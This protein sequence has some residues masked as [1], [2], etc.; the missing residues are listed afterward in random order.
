MSVLSQ[1]SVAAD[2]MVLRTWPTGETSVVASLLTADHGYVRVIAKGARGARS[3]LRALVQPGRLAALEFSLSP[4]RDLQYLRGGQV[5]LDPLASDNTLERTAY[6]LAAVEIVDRCR[7]G[8]STDRRLFELCRRFLQVLSCAAPGGGASL[9]YAFELALLDL[10]GLAPALDSC[11]TCAGGLTDRGAAGLRFSPE[12]GGVV[13]PVCSAAGSGRDGRW[14]QGTVLAA[15]RDLAAT[16]AWEDPPILPGRRVVRETGVLLHLFLTYH[17]PE[18]RLPAALDLLRS[19]RAA[20]GPHRNGPEGP[21]D[22][23]P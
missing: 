21:E 13:C 12:A 11:A 8:G 10:Q 16:G 20:D 14:L 3:T 2:A 7:P 15:L 18:Y 5:L 23:T 17:L 19:A 4:G 22:D 9:F 6:L 1:P